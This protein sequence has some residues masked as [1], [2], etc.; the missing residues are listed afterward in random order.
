MSVLV[1]LAACSAGGGNQVANGG[2]PSAPPTAPPPPD[3]CQSGGNEETCDDLSPAEQMRGV[4]VTGFER[5]GFIPDAIDAP[6]RDD[7]QAQR[8]W[9]T[10]ARGAT[11]DRS[12]WA[13]RDSRGGQAFFAIEFVGRRSRGPAPGGGYGHLNGAENLVVVDRIISL[14]VLGPPV[15]QRP[16]EGPAPGKEPE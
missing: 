12:V 10:F 9:L 7:V 13:E 11:P 1:L 3:R 2:G 16:T 6:G 14:R 5:S 15:I 4:W 8:T